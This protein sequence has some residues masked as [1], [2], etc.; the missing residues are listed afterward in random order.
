MFRRALRDFEVDVGVATEDTGA[1][2]PVVL[3]HSSPYAMP[4]RLF[5]ELECDT[6]MDLVPLLRVVERPIGQV[7][8][9]TIPDGEVGGQVTVGRVE[10]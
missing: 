1:G 7:N 3:G 4:R 10:Y 5:A 2:R 6:L 9:G 8:H